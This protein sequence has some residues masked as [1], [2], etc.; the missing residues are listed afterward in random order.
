MT[1]PNLGFSTQSALASVLT[2]T[3]ISAVFGGR[4]RRPARQ[5]PLRRTG[6]KI[7]QRVQANATVRAATH[8]LLASS[9]MR[10]VPVDVAAGNLLASADASRLPVVLVILLGA[11]SATI[12]RT[13]DEVADAQ[14]R[15]AGFRPV[16]VT[17]S[18]AMAAARRYRY[19]AELLVSEDAWHPDQQG[20]VP[21]HEYATH[22]IDLMLTAYGATASV[23][24]GPTGLD[25]A[26]RLMLQSLRPVVA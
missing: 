19:P 2:M 11:D 21:W 3:E 12:H 23:T 1:C 10:V 15:T 7:L 8:R 20:G 14:H 18:P 16:F 17:N 9:R 4:G 22:R 26:A 5:S 25:H 13:V 24:V 6:G